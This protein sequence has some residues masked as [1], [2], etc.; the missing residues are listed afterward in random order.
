VL[1]GFGLLIAV[2]GLFGAAQ[3]RTRTGSIGDAVV[4]I[5]LGLACMAVAVRAAVLAGDEG[6]TIRNPL[7]RTRHIPWA[8]ISDFKIGRYMLL[9]AVCVV[10]LCDGSTVHAWAIQI[11]RASRNPARSREARMIEELNGLVAS[12]GRPWA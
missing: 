8:A 10:E 4:A 9:D 11:P 5:V 6:I 7:G 12:R 1:I 2:L 3:S